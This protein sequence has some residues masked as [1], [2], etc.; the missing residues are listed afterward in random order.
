MG[1]IY[2][3]A[4]KKTIITTVGTSLLTNF[5]KQTSSETILNA[6]TLFDFI[7]NGD[8]TTVCAETNSL[9]RLLK[10][11]DSVLLMHSHT[12][13]GELCSDALLKYYNR[14]AIQCE[15]HEVLDLS[16]KES[17]FKVRGL[18]SLVGSL[19]DKIREENNKG[20]DVIIN[21]TGGF[22]AEIAYATLVGLL[23]KTP[24]YYIHEAFQDIIEMPT[25]PI[26][27][28]FS[29]IANHDEFFE[30]VDG[31]LRSTKDVDEKLRWL[32]DELKELRLLLAEEDGYTLLSPAGEAYYEFYKQQIW[33]SRSETIRISSK[34]KKDFTSFEASVRSVFSRE[35]S[36][37]RSEAL[38]RAN[39]E[40]VERS[41]CMVYPRRNTSERIFYYEGPD[42]VVH[43]CEL[44]RHS[45]KSYERLREKGVQRKNYGGF[46][47][48]ED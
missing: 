2:E 12:D 43:V 13:E 17:R 28:D 27:W 20:I 1:P 15:T 32:P 19:I 22:K 14:R 18:R 11:G 42:G 35:I 25:A 46:E 26:A 38:R 24:V 31:D 30:W 6:N 47:V 4:M 36:K 9:E 23:F 34:A 41:D 5:R 7:R 39:S 44:A 45:D 8:P 48:F 3:K 29:I 40:P 21:A 16:Y 10:K 33:I 37:L